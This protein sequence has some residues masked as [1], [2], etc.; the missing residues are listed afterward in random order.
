MLVARSEALTLESRDID[1]ECRPPRE[2]LDCDVQDAIDDGR[3]CSE[4]HAKT[5][6]LGSASII[7]AAI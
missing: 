5:F 2:L 6:S 7:S 3:D 4:Q 1:L